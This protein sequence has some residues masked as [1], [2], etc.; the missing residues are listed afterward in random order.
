MANSIFQIPELNYTQIPNNLFDEWIPKLKEAELRVLLVIMRQTFGWQNKSWDFISL[1]QLM[2]KTGMRKAACLRGAK[3][4]VEKKIIIKEVRG[5]IGRQETWYTLQV[6]NAEKTGKSIE[7]SNN[8]YQYPKDTGGGILKIPT[9]ET[10]TKEIPSTSSL[11]S[12]V[13][14]PKGEATHPPSKKRKKIKEE[15]QEKTKDVWI[16]PRQEIDLA[17]RIKIDSRI[18]LQMLY[19]RLSKWKISKSLTGGND[20]RC[21]TNWVIKAV[22]DDI[23]DPHYVGQADQEQIAKNRRL[24][25]KVH[26][27]FGSREDIEVT[28]SSVIFRY[29][30]KSDWQYVAITDHGFKE[31]ILNNLRRKELY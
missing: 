2:K 10:L 31:Q 6:E 9:K 24:A 22:I 4:L 14:P 20:Y 8:Y 26:D 18:S 12:E 11:R 23:N 16:T 1:S 19:D 29:G 5:R 21:I 28:G 25:Q 27:S 15:A 17:D 30:D 7:D 3:L 13:A